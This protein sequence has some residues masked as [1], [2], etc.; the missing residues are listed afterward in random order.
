[1]PR[2]GRD[3]R[4]YSFASSNV[5]NANHAISPA[6]QLPLARSAASL[7]P[8]MMPFRT[9]RNVKGLP[10]G[11]SEGM[12]GLQVTAII[13]PCIRKRRGRLVHS[14][15]T[16]RDGNCGVVT[17]LKPA[18]AH[19]PER[20]CATGLRRW[21]SRQPHQRER[22]SLQHSITFEHNGHRRR[23]GFLR[24]GRRSPL[25]FPMPLGF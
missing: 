22:N 19:E 16:V 21:R 23:P 25:F 2:F 9:R 4:I 15:A 5:S 3:L 8:N 24:P 1:M 18:V 6:K 20:T 13:A 17:R 11:L 10:P 12:R 14:C 7:P